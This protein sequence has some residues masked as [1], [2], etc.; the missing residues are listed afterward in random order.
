VRWFDGRP[1]IS[2]LETLNKDD[3]FLILVTA[4]VSYTM[5][6]AP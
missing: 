2:T 3:A 6:I 4:P 1:D 5:P